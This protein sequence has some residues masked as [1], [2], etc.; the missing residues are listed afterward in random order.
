MKAALLIFFS[1]FFPCVANGVDTPWWTQAPIY[2]IFVRSFQDSNNDGIGDLNGIRQRLDYLKSERPNSL[3][4]GALWLTPIFPTPSYHGYDVTDYRNVNPEYGTLEDFELLVKESHQRGLKIILDLPVNHSSAK[5]PWFLDS[6]KGENTL[7]RDWYFWRRD[8]PSWGHWFSLADFF[9]L[10]FF[11]P[12]MPQ[13]NWRNPQFLSEVESIFEFWTQKG[14]DGF[15]LDAVRHYVPGPNGETDTE[16]THVAIQKFTRKVKEHFPLTLFVGEI[17]SDSATI[18]SYYHGGSELDMALSF[19]LSYGLLDSLKGESSERLASSLRENKTQIGFDSFNSPFLTNHDMARLSTQLQGDSRKLLLAASS[20][21]AL[22][23]TPVVYYGEEL[24]MSNGE[25]S[26]HPGD[27]AQ[28]VPMQWNQGENYGFT[29]VGVSP[30][31][32]FL[33]NATQWSVEAQETEGS[34]LSRYRDLIKLRSSIPALQTG[35]LKQIFEAPELGL[36]SW[37]RVKPHSRVVW[38]GNFSSRSVKQVFIPVDSD[39]A[40]KRVQA[41]LLFQSGSPEF[42]FQLQGTTLQLYQLTPFSSFLIEVTEE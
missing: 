2:E 29:G 34:L 42:K 27:L 39:L 30:W 23:G 16:E 10:S 37:Q 40:R 25:S 32:S 15:R 8:K 1:A 19:P 14:V 31:Q 38:S 3:G 5:H 35:E 24:G 12:S 26:S 33:G 4:V 7:F 17:W 22:P 9:Y 28:R 36:V 20:L 6:Q 18:A 41:R 11:D 21:M 13:L